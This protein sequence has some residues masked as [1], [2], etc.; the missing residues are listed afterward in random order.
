MPRMGKKG[1]KQCCH[2]LQGEFYSCGYRMTAA[3]EAI[4]KVLSK[5]PEHP[6]VEDI[7]LNVHQV[8]PRIGL[9][10]VYRTLEL[11]INNGLVHKFDCGEGKA[12][13]EL[14]QEISKNDHHYHLICTQC[15]SIIN[16]SDF[17][18]EEKDFFTRIE[19]RVLTKYKF[20]ATHHIIQFY[21][22][23]NSCKTENKE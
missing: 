7:Y 14:S 3:R 22:L 20:N 18:E 17:D 2:G 23:C 1:K 9:T 11:L 4:L 8:Y 5:M 21:G 6:S 13:Y 15:K 10:T 16:Y 12:R 19:K